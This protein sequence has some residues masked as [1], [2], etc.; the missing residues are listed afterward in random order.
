[1]SAVITE[2]R[3]THGLSDDHREILEQVDKFSKAHFWELQERMDNDE[4][5]PDDALPK[6]GETGF[7]GATVPPELGGAG[8]DFAASGLVLQGVARWNPSLSL[9]VLAHENLCLNNILH[10]ANDELKEKYLPGMCAGTTVGCLSL[11]E[12]GAGSDALGGMATTARLDGDHYVLNGTKI[13]ITNGPVADVSLVYAKTSPDKGAKG[14]TAFVVDTDTPGFN[15]AQKLVKM[16][17]RGTQTAEIVFDDC[18]VPVANVVGEVDKGVNVVMSGLDLERI[19]LSYM[20]LGMAERCLE[21]AVDY[22]KDRKQFGKTIGEFQ[23]VQGMLAEMYTEVE[24]LRSFCYDVGGEVSQI[25]H[26]AARSRVHK[27]SAALVLQAGLMIM[28][29]ADAAVQV[30]GGAGYIWEMEI[31]RLYRA[32]KLLQIGAGTNEVRKIIIARELLGS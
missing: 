19:G 23:L 28:R 5:W 29:V 20:I 32:G 9:G 1:M 21:L 6:L 31:N 18:R 13:Y 8:L 27:R 2:S 22:A 3:Q 14:I 26:G 17:M 4:W 24:V 25:E 15:V 30:H 16:G 11:T 12:P 10:N 7:L